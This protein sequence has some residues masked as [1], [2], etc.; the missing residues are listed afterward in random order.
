MRAEAKHEGG[1]SA[2]RDRSEGRDRPGPLVKVPVPVRELIDRLEDGGFETWTV[3]GAVRDA[4]QGVRAGAEDWDLATRARP[5]EV[6]RLFRRTVALGKAYGTIGVFGA[7]DVL[8][9]VTTFR[10]DVVTYGRRAKVEFAETL[11]EDLARRDFTVNAMAWHPRRAELRDL[12]GGR[13][14]LRDR[15]LRTVGSPRK[16]FSED[17]LR[18][19]RGL[20][21]AGALGMEID[22]DTWDGM[23]EAVTGLS[24]LSMERVREELEKVLTGP[25]PSPS[26]DLYRRSGALKQVLPELGEG[27]SADALATVDELDGG[28]WLLRVAA[29]LLFGMDPGDATPGRVAGLLARLRFSGADAERIGGAVRGGP[30]P[31]TGI[32]DDPAA[33]RR[34]VA[35]MTRGGARSVPDIQ[36]IWEAAALAAPARTSPPAV[37]RLAADIQGDRAAGIP[38]EVRD[39]PVAGRDLVARGWPPGP[40]I[41]AALRSLLEA[42][43]GDP[44]L[45]DRAALLERVASMKPTRLAE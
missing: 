37:A 25:R 36:R 21:F 16:R 42:V 29:L 40:G 15:I 23:R 33:R 12:H 10:R 26:L 5:D 35:D 6:Q 45:N 8:Y 7:D 4:L 43:W 14:D 11:D 2:R 34:W 3:G 17:Y 1:R 32:A 44:D 27:P 20:R 28:E 30:A 9:E 38:V 13:S 22:G 39:L 24:V 31:P 18:V 19:L 41:G